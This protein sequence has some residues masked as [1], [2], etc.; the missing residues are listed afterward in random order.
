MSSNSP[1]ISH[2]GTAFAA[3][4]TGSARFSRPMQLDEALLDHM[5][6]GADPE[7]LRELAHSTA[8]ALLDRVHHTQDAQVVQRV[9][10]VVDT[11]GIEPI[12]ELWSSAD[13][14][15]LPGILWRLYTMRMWMQKNQRSLAVL[16]TEGELPPTAA[17]AITGMTSPVS[18][19]DV[20]STADSILSGAF[21]GDFAVALDRASSFCH[22][23]ARALVERAKTRPAG[24]HR[25]AIV[26]N[27]RHLV[28]TAKDFSAGAALWRRGELY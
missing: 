4:R 18:A 24:A 13:A 17:S 16:W 11:E 14:L 21:S 6:G 25:D 20:A 22:V 27:A 12:A 5:A 23:V 2:A 19:E 15:S 10:T 26:A 9:I 1:S 28:S 3:T 7:A 8:A